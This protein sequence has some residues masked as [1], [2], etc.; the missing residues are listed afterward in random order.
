VGWADE[1]PR[2]LV[3]AGYDQSGGAGVLA[4]VKTLEANGVYAFAVCTALTFQNER[5]ISKVEW[6]SEASI[7][8]Q[9]DIC[10]ESG[11][12]EWVK[13]GITESMGSAAAIV[14]HLK[15][16]HPGVR[17]VLDPVIRASSGKD[18][19][20]AGNEGWEELAKACFLVTPNWEE[21]GMLY[22]VGEEMERCRVLSKEGPHIYLKGG[23]HPVHPGKDYLWSGGEVQALEADGRKVY[24]KHGSGCVLA[25][26]LTA[27]LAL[28]HS[29]EAA[30][31]KAKRYTAGFLA[32]NKT[33]LGW[34]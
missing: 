28:G 5:R 25:S 6:L 21:I 8:E 23:H 22:A 17:V 34:H 4:D 12:F 13:M 11:E 31:A 2:V 32:S 33:L 20:G 26:S 9:V 19:W 7:L 30:A 16:R 10:A 24:P 27:N 1:R 14:G 18:F 15:R 29:L 3:L